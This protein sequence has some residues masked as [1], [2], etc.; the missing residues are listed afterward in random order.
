MARLLP[1]AI[2]DS[3]VSIEKLHRIISI[4]P[5]ISLVDL[6][7]IS[8]PIEVGYILLPIIFSFLNNNSTIL[9]SLLYW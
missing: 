1:I 3:E 7:L 8:G 9:F 4:F 2:K 5:G 6:E